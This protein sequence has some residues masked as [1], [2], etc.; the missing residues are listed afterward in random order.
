MS[1]V[2]NSARRHI[3][4][5]VERMNSPGRIFRM[6]AGVAA[7]AVALGFAIAFGVIFSRRPSANAGA[8]VAPLGELLDPGCDALVPIRAAAFAQALR[9]GL[10]VDAETRD[11]A[12]AVVPDGSTRC[13]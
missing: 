8:P 10:L 3:A 7:T 9:D 12:M 2:A 11:R 13:G 4:D 1:S 6:F 5:D